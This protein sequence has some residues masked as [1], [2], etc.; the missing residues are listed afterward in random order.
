MGYPT[1]P[2]GAAFGGIT[3]AV[4][5]VSQQEGN[6]V[7]LGVLKRQVPWD[8]YQ[9]ADLIS[10]RELQLI[11][12]YDKQTRETQQRLLLE[13]EGVLY[14]NAFFS[15][16][17]SIASEEVV[18]YVLALLEDM[19]KEGGSTIVGLLKRAT[20]GQG[21]GDTC[22]IL[23]RMLQ[24]PDW[25]TQE[26]AAFV[27]SS[28]LSPA[29]DTATTTTTTSSSSSAGQAGQS[30][31]EPLGSSHSVETFVEW[32]CNEL[33]RPSNGRSEETTITCL[34]LLLRNQNTREVFLKHNGISALSVHLVSS[35]KTQTLYE[36]CLCAWLLSFCKPAVQEIL[37]LNIPKKLVDVVKQANKEK[38][39]RVAI[40]CLENIL[41]DVKENYSVERYSKLV[42]KLIENGL[43]KYVAT[44]KM[45]SYKD[46]ELIESMDW[47]EEKLEAEVVLKISQFD[48]YADEVLSGTLD[49]TLLHKQEKFW[50]MNAANFVAKDCTI[51]KALAR[52]LETSTDERTLEV[53]CHDIGQFISHYPHGRGFMNALKVKPLVMKLMVHPDPEVQK[54]ALMCTQKLMLSKDSLDLLSLA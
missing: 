50:K 29:G 6:E 42:S 5:A 41:K 37:Q 46:E 33:R 51:L 30:T 43:R 18:Q 49:W 44:Q 8:T 26:K 31:S 4:S 20:T 36:V 13:E 32:L 39:L 53:A 38:V 7:T 23:L 19:I 9:K 45:N 24:R 15:L 12:R 22:A 16:L 27:L 34:S 40:M 2:S 11:K 52:L 35:H 10:D 14:V 54:Q 1:N 48:E 47:L 3:E 17:R 21:S 28:L 25:F